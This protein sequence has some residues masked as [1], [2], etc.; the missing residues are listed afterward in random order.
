MQESHKAVEDEN[1][2]AKSFTW[3]ATYTEK[4]IYQRIKMTS[5]LIFLF[6]KKHNELAKFASYKG[7]LAPKANN[8]KEPN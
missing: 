2:T 4:I 6:A 1:I 3:K 8:T 5:I 7:E